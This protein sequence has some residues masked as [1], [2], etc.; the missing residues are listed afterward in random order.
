M[1]KYQITL[2]LAFL[3]NFC[4]YSQ[5][6]IVI[7]AGHGGKDPGAIQNKVKEKDITLKIALKVGN[8]LT[9][10]VKNIKVVQTRTKDVFVELN[11]RAEIANKNK[12]DLFISIHVNSNKDKKIQGTSTYVMGLHK[13]QENLEVAVYE[14]SSIL[15]ENNYKN[16]YNNFDPNSPESY[17][18]FNLYQ[19]QNLETSIKFAEKLQW[20][21]KNKSKRF[22][23][24]VRQ[25]GFLVLWQ[26]TMPS[27]LVEVGFLSNADEAKFLSSEYGQDLIASAIYRAI[28]DFLDYL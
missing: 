17:I 16:T 20:Q 4:L 19:N 7:D 10:N 3:L 27:V 8:Y 13:S 28:K 11:K 22:D 23:K 26:T 1:L 18:I 9:N 25:A 6:I 24:G 12:A 2:I 15:Y 5:K 14:N 21:F